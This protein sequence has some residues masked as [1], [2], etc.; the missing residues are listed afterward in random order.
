MNTPEATVTRYFDALAERNLSKVAELVSDNFAFVNPVEPMN[1][2]EFLRFMDGLLTGFP[3]YCFNHS[4]LRVQGNV[5][6]AKLRMTGTHT[7]ELSLP[8]PG[9]KP[10]PPTK[11][12]VVLPEQR[13]DYAVHNG[14][15]TT[16]TPEPLP[17]AGIIGLLEQIGVKLPPL[18]VMKLITKLSKPFRK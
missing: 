10:I 8:M 4:D 18:W 11:K 6:T 13:F 12:K 5:V 2:P 1:K 15:I 14:R 9:L 3:D 16:I 17:H 7:H